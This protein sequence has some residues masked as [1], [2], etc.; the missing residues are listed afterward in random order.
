MGF[1][2][3][4]IGYP[5]GLIMYGIYS[6]VKDY[7]IALI[8]FTILT[9]LLLS[10]LSINNNKMS[11]KQKA[12]APQ[13][14][15]LRKSYANNPTRLQEEQM[16]LYNENN[17]NPMA[18][19]LPLLIQLPIIYGILDVVYRPLT[20]IL[21]L[22]KDMINQ[23]TEVLNNYFT[24]EGIVDKAMVSRPELVIL[25]YVK[26]NPGIFEGVEGFAESV[27]G[28][29][30][31]LFNGLIDLGVTPTIHPEV[32][33]AQAVALCMI[34]VVSGLFQL[35]FTVYSQMKQKRDNPE[36]AKMMGGMNIMLYTMPIISVWFTFSFPAGVGF[37]WALSSVFSLIQA[38]IIDKM[39][40]PA[41][42]EKMLK[43]E[44]EKAKNKKP[45]FMEKMMEQQ[46]A[47][48][49]EQASSGRNG[50]MS[51]SELNEYQRQLINEAR[52]RMA[53]KYGDG[54]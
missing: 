28:F 24:T 48:L 11:A 43:K 26:Q 13:L 20:H 25:Q 4:I 35:I 38:I 44:R 33:N 12:I 51:K 37:Y 17:I 1:L 21:R 42:V 9:K 53:D 5:L 39:M 47:M 49:E 2:S 41:Y 29:N 52:K 54:N 40:T 46:K 31:T 10:P 23:A 3:S 50:S 36:A 6:L 16:K 15:K 8:L 27:S 34:P 32:W 18:G 30:N 14:E 7:G 22:P 45:G 19:C